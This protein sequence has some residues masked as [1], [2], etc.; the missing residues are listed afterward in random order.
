MTLLA[1][2]WDEK[3]N[4]KEGREVEGK[5]AWNDEDSVNKWELMAFFGYIRYTLN[6]SRQFVREFGRWKVSI[7]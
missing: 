7:A 5:E 4:N 2:E 6:V 3:K 1:K